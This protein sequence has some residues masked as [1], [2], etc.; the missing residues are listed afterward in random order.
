MALLKPPIDPIFRHATTTPPSRL[1]KL[2]RKA[3]N[4]LAGKPDG[5]TVQAVAGMLACT[6]SEALDALQEL[7]KAA[8]CYMPTRGWKVRLRSER[9]Q[10]LAANDNRKRLVT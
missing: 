9:E 8:I 3:R 1:A 2:T 7:G 6:E 10:W 4:I 5:Y